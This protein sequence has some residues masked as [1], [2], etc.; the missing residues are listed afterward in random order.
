MVEFKDDDF[1]YEVIHPGLSR[2]E[3][4]IRITG[5]TEKGLETLKKNNQHL[6]IPDEIDIYRVTVIWESAFCNCGIEKLTLGKYIYTIDV[7]SFKDNKI[8]SVEFPETVGFIGEG[9]FAYNEV[10][11]II[12]LPGNCSVQ[13]GAFKYMEDSPYLLKE[14]QLIYTLIK[15]GD[16]K[17]EATITGVRKKEIDNIKS[18]RFI[19]LPDHIR[20]IEVKTISDE[21]FKGLGLEY[22]KLPI[23]LENICKGAFQNN[24]L[25]KVTITRDIKH[26]DG[27]AFMFN[28]GDF[29]L[30]FVRRGWDISD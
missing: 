2:E 27:S 11:E 15:N 17:G 28:D 22:V 14:K 30:E 19:A 4:Y 16:G 12:S 5:L 7:D 29:S 18:K 21:A 24:K 25:K 20:K 26:I 10:K 23:Y 8:Q 3:P 13:T 6:V 1:E 9:A